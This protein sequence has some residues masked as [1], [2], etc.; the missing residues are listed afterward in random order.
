MRLRVTS[1]SRPSRR[2]T[3]CLCLW[4][5]LLAMIIS[6]GGCNPWKNK[7]EQLLDSV[8]DRFDDLIDQ[9]RKIDSHDSLHA[10]LPEI[11]SIIQRIKDLVEE[12]KRIDQEAG[13]ELV[14]KEELD[15]RKEVMEEKKQDMRKEMERIRS[16]PGITPADLFAL[17]G[18]FFSM[19]DIGG[20]SRATSHFPSPAASRGGAS[21]S[22][23]P[24]PAS[25]SNPQSPPPPPPG[26]QGERIQSAE[27]VAQKVGTNRTCRLVMQDASP[28]AAFEARM[29][30]QRQSILATRS[31]ASGGPPAAEAGN[32]FYAFQELQGKDWCVTFGPIDDLSV[33]EKPP[34]YFEVVR[35]DPVRREFVWKFLPERYTPFPR[36]PRNRDRREDRN[37]DLPSPAEPAADAAAPPRSGESAPAAPEKDLEDLLG[38]SPQDQQRALNHLNVIGPQGV[39]S[40]DLRKQIARAMKQIAFDKHAG[41]KNRGAAIEGLTVW[42]G[43][44]SVPLLIELLDDQSLRGPEYSQ[45]LSALSKFHDERAVKPLAGQLASATS[46]R[47]FD[48]ILKCLE[49]FGAKAEDEVLKQFPAR[50]PFNTDKLLRFFSEYGTRKCLP[51]LRAYLQTPAARR[52]AAEVRQTIQAVNHRKPQ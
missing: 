27:E 2:R 31:P 4:G 9:L 16:I 18:T 34:E 41:T 3:G 32:R 6:S 20:P 47:R 15:R 10:A 8:E 43:K 35:L 51:K 17:A 40:S 38:G 26:G 37:A 28:G 5:L 52:H 12:A 11:K 39:A 1:K 29:R 19:A 49:T 7:A 25:F 13:Q 42:G 50:S 36:S 45:L 23:P 33:F 48:E 14:S 46:S 44:Y 30:V 22:L 24:P 21:P